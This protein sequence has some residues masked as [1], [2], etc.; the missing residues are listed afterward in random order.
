MRASARA[1]ALLLM[2]A[3]A[4]LVDF[5]TEASCLAAGDAEVAG[6]KARD[7]TAAMRR[8]WWDCAARVA[9]ASARAGGAAGLDNEIALEARTLQ[10]RLGA[11]RGALDETQRGA[12]A[13]GAI[14]PAFQWAE[15]GAQ[16]FVNCKFA[17]KIDAP[18]TLD[19]EVSRPRKTRRY[20]AGA[21]R[22]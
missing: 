7:V 16:L 13:R 12:G 15:S 22:G 14:A 4:Q 9:E 2:C 5:D 19:V 6:L 11:L 20:A 1:A 3:R 18:A 21:A 10:A 8:G 17:H